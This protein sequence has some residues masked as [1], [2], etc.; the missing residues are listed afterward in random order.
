MENDIILK[1]APFGFD[2]KSVMDFIEDL[3]KKNEELRSENIRLQA[4]NESLKN[5]V[6]SVAAKKEED[7]IL[8]KYTDEPVARFESPSYSGYETN[9]S[10]EDLSIRAEDLV[11][12]D[13][14]TRE[15][16]EEQFKLAYDAVSTEEPKKAKSQTKRRPAKITTKTAPKKVSVQKR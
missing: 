1:T 12:A 5:M 2:K 10:Y 16:L 14:A 4:E 7:T 8:S 6:S 13:K 9:V 15:K 3:Q 11:M